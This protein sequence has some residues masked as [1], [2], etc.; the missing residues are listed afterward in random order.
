MSPFLTL[1]LGLLI[2]YFIISGEAAVIL[3]AIAN[4]GAL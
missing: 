3:A 2:L 4:L 1:W